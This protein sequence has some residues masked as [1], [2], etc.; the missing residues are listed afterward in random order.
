MVSVDVKNTGHRLGSEVVQLY[1]TFP[2]SAGEPPRQLKAFR[3][4][5]LVPGQTSTAHFTLTQRDVS[6]WSEGWMVPKGEFTVHVGASSR[7]IR[8]SSTLSL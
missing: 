1:V 8:L 6:V 3:K 7:D 4:V 2:A 5:R